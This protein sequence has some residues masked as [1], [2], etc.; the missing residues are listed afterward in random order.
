MSKLLG[1]INL[2]KEHDFLNELTYFRCGAAVPFAG[3][4]R[5]IDFTMVN[6][7]HSGI[8]ELG[9]FTK[10]K[11]RSLLD[12]LHVGK[13]WN[14][15]RKKGGLFIL[16]PDWHDPSDI[17][18]GELRH[19]ANNMDFFERSLADYVLHCGSQNICKVNYK[20]VL[21]Q[22]I[23]TGADVTLIYNPVDKLESEHS[24]CKRLDIK[25]NGEVQNI[26]NEV[27]NKN[28][29]MDMFIINKDLLI[30]LIQHCIAHR[31]DN[32]FKGGIMD[33]IND[34]KIYSY[35]YDG[36]HA[37][38]NSIESYYKNN[39]R[40][41]NMED[42]ISLFM[43]GKPVPT[44]VKDEV[45]TRYLENADVSNSLVANGCI[46][47]G[48]VENSMIFRGVKVEKGAYIKDSIVMSRAVIEEDVSL[49]NVILDKKVSVSK[50]QHLSGVEE[51]PFVLAKR[52][53]V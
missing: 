5:L 38:I 8:T 49:E 3:R 4:Y 47:D 52:K 48:V 36:Y 22:H 27:D 19:F 24:E 25:S 43:Q 42:Y 31:K 29:Y 35:R 17:S 21:K 23:D 51:K 53:S 28:I 14:L 44:K 10:R 9:I 18:V 50:G 16:P 13:Q 37:V 45:P 1:V 33:N 30:E 7:V 20:D 2:D 26:H 34:L 6:M 40:L 11:Y 15:D 32:F 12:H 39:M 46:I 41:L